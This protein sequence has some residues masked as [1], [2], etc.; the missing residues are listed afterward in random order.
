MYFAFLT[1][2]SETALLFDANHGRQVSNKNQGPSS[3]QWNKIGKQTS[4][5][6]LIS[7]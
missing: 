6:H 7:V 3:V 2:D 5:L 1:K 4:E